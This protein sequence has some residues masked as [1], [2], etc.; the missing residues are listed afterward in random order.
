MCIYICIARTSSCTS[1]GRFKP[2]PQSTLAISPSYNHVAV[3]SETNNLMLHAISLSILTVFAFLSRCVPAAAETAAE[4]SQYIASDGVIYA[5]DKI[6]SVAMSGERDYTTALLLTSESGRYDCSFCGV[7]GPNFRTVAS[8][9]QAQIPK[10]GRDLIFILADVEAATNTFR[11]LGITHVPNL[12]IYPPTKSRSDAK[13]GIQGQHE[14][15]SFSSVNGEIEHLASVFEQ[16]G[17]Y[18]KIIKQFPWLKVSQAVVTLTLLCAGGFI[19][20]SQILKVWQAKQI[21]LALSLMGVIMFISGHMF[22]VTR[23][24][25]FVGYDGH[26]MVMIDPNLNSQFA[27]ETQIIATIYALLAF[28]SIGLIKFVPKLTNP[29]AQT[30]GAIF[31]AA[32]ILLVYS[33]LLET[34]KLKSKLPLYLLPVKIF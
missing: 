23:G 1:D 31:G 28:T 22:N 19:F 29:K 33:I 21:W 30:I 8:S 32:V 11:T 16:R 7:L 24:T 17:F 25:Q 2:S 26:N 10:N 20:Q 5:D 34:F 6:M 4:L 3:S 13:L 27:V 15:I 9:Y 14:F 12:V 18:I